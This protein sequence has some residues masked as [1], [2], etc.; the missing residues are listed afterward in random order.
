MVKTRYEPYDEGP[1]TDVGS[2]VGPWRTVGGAVMPEQIEFWIEEGLPA[3]CPVH[4]VVLV[5][6]FQDPVQA[7]QCPMESCTGRVNLSEMLTSAD[8][9]EVVW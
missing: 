5:F 8:G 3:R 1:R 7:W 2:E 6:Q 9:G 4:K